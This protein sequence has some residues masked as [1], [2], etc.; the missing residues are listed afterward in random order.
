MWPWGENRCESCSII[1][2]S[3]AEQRRA[4][5]TFRQTRFHGIRRLRPRAQTLVFTFS[6]AVRS[7]RQITGPVFVFHACQPVTWMT[8]SPF[9]PT[10]YKEVECL[11][12]TLQFPLVVLVLLLLLFWLFALHTCFVQLFYTPTPS[13]QLFASINVSLFLQQVTPPPTLPP[14]VH[15]S[16]VS[17]VWFWISTLF[18]GFDV[19]VALNPRLQLKDIG[20]QLRW[21]YLPAKYT[22]KNIVKW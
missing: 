4:A 19:Y 7:A 9:S 6:K 1:S 5:D 17:T 21:V 11:Y 14:H 13:I 20:K 8:A 16:D 3:N 2:L 12:S 18:I 15:I 10:S 22:G